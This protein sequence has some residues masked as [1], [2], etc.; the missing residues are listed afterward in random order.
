M[1]TFLQQNDLE[2]ISYQYICC[3][4]AVRKLQYRK[5]VSSLF[6]NTFIL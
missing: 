1:L 4:K 2:S 5:G 6:R 3:V